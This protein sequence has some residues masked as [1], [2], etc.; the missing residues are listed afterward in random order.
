MKKRFGLCLFIV[1]LLA[2][3]DYSQKLSI[4]DDSPC[5]YST[6][7]IG[8]IEFFS[9][10]LGK[11]IANNLSIAAKWS[12]FGVGTKFGGSASIGI[13]ANYF[14]NKILI[15]R[16]LS[17]DYLYMYGG[18]FKGN[19]FEA[20][21]G[22]CTNREKGFGFVYELGIGYSDVEA[23][24]SYPPYNRITLLGPIIKIGLNYNF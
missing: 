9:V 3:T 7:T 6:I 4:E 18:G 23:K 8:G 11:Y 16:Y 1:F 5:L 22:N 15:F 21:F 19:G 10:S 2:R 17:A 20:V 12:M 14:F 24:Y 13:G